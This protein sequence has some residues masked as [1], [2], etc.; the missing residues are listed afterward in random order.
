MC[1]K[2]I[3]DIPI[4]KKAI[5]EIS[6]L[7]RLFSSFSQ[8]K[9]FFVLA[10]LPNGE[11]VISRIFNIN[12]IEELIPYIKEKNNEIKEIITLPDRFNDTFHKL[13][14]ILYE[15]MD[16]EVTREALAIASIDNIAKAEEILVE[17]YSEENIRWNLDLMKSIKAYLP[18]ERL[19][20]KA[21]KDYLEERYHACIP[22]ILAVLDGI[23]NEVYNKQKGFFA[24]DINLIVDG[25]ISAHEKGLEQLAV[26]FSKGRR[27]T[28]TDKINIPYRNGIMHGMDLGYDNK[29]VAAKTWAALFSIREWALRVERGE[30]EPPLEE[31][32]GN[33][34]KSLDIY[35]K[36]KQAQELIKNWK[37]RGIV[38]GKNVPKTGIP[39]DYQNNSPEKKLIEFLSYW[40][41]KNYG[42]MAECVPVEDDMNPNAMPKEIREVYQDKEL[43][44]Y[45]IKEI[46]EKAIALTIINVN[47]SYKE[48]NNINI[49]KAEFKLLNPKMTQELNFEPSENNHWEII[50]WFNP[51]F[52][53]QETKK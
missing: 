42:G 23:V 4:F 44:S 51:N 34:E 45:E 30:T 17:Y 15:N 32:E 26:L 7:E 28:V 31:S 39:D 37:P 53:K 11:D 2:L 24:K 13:G 5:E 22:V 43:L 33:I 9:P 16:L 36:A 47:L 49:Y 21:F 52:L 46:D 20:L 41:K 35:K 27:K 29:I 8:L 3:K 18:R 48:N 50:N 1:K 25:S 10:G 14:W 38:I 6:N 40:K 12:Y 19:V